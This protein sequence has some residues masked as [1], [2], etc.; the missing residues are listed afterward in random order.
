M[1]IIDIKKSG[2][3]KKS[4]F[5]K[6]KWI[7]LSLLVI[8]VGFLIFSK[9][10]PDYQF[11]AVKTGSITES[12]SLTGNTTPKQDVTLS[13]GTSGTVAKTYSDLGKEVKAGD[14]LAELNISDLLSQLHSAEAGLTL[15]K[16]EVYASNDNLSNV[17]AEQDAIVARA[18]QNIYTNFTAVPSDDFV[19]ATAPVISGSY[20][21]SVDGS[22]T[23]KVYASSSGTGISFNYSGL[24]SGTEPVTT[25]SDV[26]LGTH[27]LFI[28]FPDAS[29]PGNSYLNTTWTID[30]PNIRSNTYATAV[31]DYE[32]ALETRDKAIAAAQANV[33]ISGQS[34]SEAKIAQANATIEGIKARIRD[35]MIIA[36]ISG[37]ITQFDA[38]VGQ[39]ATPN[40]PLI[41]IMSSEGYEVDAGVSETDIG[42]ISIGDTVSMTLDAFPNETFSG[43]VFYIAPAETNNQGVI[44]YEVKISFNDNDSRI[45]SGLTANI[46]IET[47]KKDNVLILPQYAIL[48]NDDGV[49]VQTVDEDGK[50]KDNPVTLGIQDRDGN[51]EIISG[52][53]DGEQVLNIGLKAK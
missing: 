19:S 47:Q 43:S 20:N 1:K 5:L 38:E 26:P 44:S 36:P 53:T 37:L 24:E 34:V 35:A 11:V 50:T 41:S 15:A 32:T 4:K 30:V 33:G 28:R 3:I 45:K 29:T 48:Q 8:L 27:G 42:K 12:V 49:F 52:V 13:F 51:V 17:I 40:T 23:I 10:D 22:Y 18:H 21:G 9:H 6:P 16:Q 14:V 31:K 7:I 2:F 25:T 39:L 46:D